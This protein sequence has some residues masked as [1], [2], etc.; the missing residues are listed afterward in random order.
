MTSLWRSAA[1]T[2]YTSSSQS[3]LSQPSSVG[4]AAIVGDERMSALALASLRH[5]ARLLYIVIA[6]VA[7]R[8]LTRLVQKCQFVSMCALDFV[9]DSLCVLVRRAAQRKHFIIFFFIIVVIVERRLVGVVVGVVVSSSA[10][11]GCAACWLVSEIITN[12]DRS[13]GSLFFFLFFFFL[14]HRCWLVRASVATLNCMRGSLPC[15][16][17][18]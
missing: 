13:V 18:L 3:S 10:T 1:L 4:N 15:A 11:L 7:D 9:F 17:P 6:V 8:P 2:P 5:A 12:I 14:L 16:A